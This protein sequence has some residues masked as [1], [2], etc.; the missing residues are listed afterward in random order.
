MFVSCFFVNISKNVFIKVKLFKYL[1]IIWH[2]IQ[3]ACS[4]SIKLERTMAVTIIGLLNY[5]IKMFW[6]I[7]LKVYLAPT[8]VQCQKISLWQFCLIANRML[9]LLIQTLRLNKETN[10]IIFSR[11]TNFFKLFIHMTLVYDLWKIVSNFLVLQ[12]N[13]LSLFLSDRLDGFSVTIPRCYKNTFVN[14]I[15]S[16]TCRL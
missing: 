6:G 13:S 12:N 1:F 16:R 7:W 2:Y 4:F 15:F 3:H 9:H 14:S 11:K 5:I 10:K 8:N